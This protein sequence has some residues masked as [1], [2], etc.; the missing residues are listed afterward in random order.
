MKLMSRL[1]GFAALAVAG[2][3]GLSAPVTAQ[4]GGMIR[5]DLELVLAVDISQSMDYDEHSIQRQ[6]YVDAF[7][8]KDVVNAMLSG[9]EGKVAVLYMEWA[10][11]FDPI[12]TIPWT[13]IDS[14]EAATKFS[15][16]LENEPIYGEQRTSIS[17]ALETAQQHILKNNISSHRQVIDVSGDG[18]NNAGR[19]VEPARPPPSPTATDRTPRSRGGLVVR[20][21]R[22][23]AALDAVGGERRGRSL[24]PLPLPPLLVRWPRR[25]GPAGRNCSG[26]ARRRAAPPWRAAP[27]RPTAATERGRC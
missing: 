9:P 25:R 6:G 14:T 12:E 17:R 1:K 13:I 24:Q 5:V 19:L 23:C 2:F 22:L 16:R 18:A 15:E 11:D 10:G 8:H 27:G 7:R 4:Q 3:V 20:A 26:R 21:L